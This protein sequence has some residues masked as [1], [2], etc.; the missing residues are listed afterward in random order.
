MPGPPGGG[1]GQSGAPR[2]PA[3]PSRRRGR[4][5]LPTVLIVAGILIAFSI[6]T[7]FYTD[8]LWYQSV[9][10]TG[11]FTTTIRSKAL[12]FFTFGILFAVAVAVNV[13]VAYRKRPTYQA[14]IPGQ[15]ELDRYR[16]ALDPYR[17]LVLIAVS[18]LLGLIAGSSAS[19]AWRT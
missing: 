7:G 15:A 3:M 16:T 2:R 17:R 6:F 5:L 4:V 1:A 12:L 13:V 14:M 8:L 11:V 18:V 19:G 10:Y 9:D